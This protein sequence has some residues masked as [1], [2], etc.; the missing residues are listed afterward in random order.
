MFGYAVF[1][2]AQAAG[3]LG[4]RAAEG[5]G[6]YGAGVGRIDEAV[7]LD[8]FVEVGDDYPRAGGGNEVGSVDVDD[9]VEAGH[10]EDD[11]TLHR[12]GAA[13][14]VGARAAGID[15]DALAVG[16][17]HDEGDF[18]GVRGNDD[19]VRKVGETRRGVVGIAQQLFPAGEDVLR[20]DDLLEGVDKLALH[21]SFS[22]CG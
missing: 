20:A 8:R 15:G 16:Q 12:H 1:Q 11:A 6:G 19:D 3:V 9:A 7:L 14:E 18:L 22:F 2:A 10:E 5:G 21:F 4:D 13:A 17:G